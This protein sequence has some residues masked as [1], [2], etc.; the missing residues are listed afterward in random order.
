MK[1]TTKQKLAPVFAL[2]LA[3]LAT[4]AL[5]Y[6]DIP[7]MASVQQAFIQ[8]VQDMAT[9]AINSVITQSGNDVASQVSRSSYGI[10]AEISKG[11]IVQ[12]NTS[13]AIAMYE[14]QERLRIQAIEIN[15]KLRQP[16]T[17]CASMAVG[18]NV[19]KVAAIVQ[20]A[21]S[22]RTR[23]TTQSIL[24]RPSNSVAIIASYDNSMKKYCT[25]A[26]ADLHRC[27]MGKNGSD[28]RLAGADVQA[29]MLFNS[30]DPA[31]KSP[32]TYIPGQAAAMKDYVD[33]IAVSMPP[34]AIAARSLAEERTPQG[35]A[36]AEL[37]RRYASFMSMAAYSLNSILSSHDVQV[38]L[39]DRTMMAA[40]VG[41]DASMM[42]VVKAFVDEKFSAKSMKDQ[43]SQLQSEVILRDM[44]Q[45]NA[46]RLWIDYQNLVQTQRIEAMNAMQ[47]A[48]MTEAQLKPQLA[49]QRATVSSR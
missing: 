24:S 44:A 29:D 9:S 25:Q 1:I 39:G 19:G 38:G 7:W 22:A 27:E 42:A 12:K 3:T 17:T 4:P 11:A 45:T 2:C 18:D 32:E 49:A 36:Y 21:S 48:L 8:K 37:A 35:K 5:A 31:A 28:K 33:R 47:L 10:Q 14:S 20:N 30:A 26:D 13:E 16:A 34:E 41:S 46:F 15:E 23:S 40:R 43:G 6:S